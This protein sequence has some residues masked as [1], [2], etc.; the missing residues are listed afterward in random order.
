MVLSK[1]NSDI[2]YPEIKSVDPVDLK[3][4]ANLYQIDVKDVEIIIAVG[5]SKNTFEDKNILYFPIYLVKHNNKVVQIGIYEILS[6]NYINYLD[7]SNNLNVEKLDNKFIYSFIRFEYSFFG[8]TYGLV[9][10][11]IFCS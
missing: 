8:N 9:L 11:E 5:N 2:S 4:E 1:I 7:N 3:Q 10:Y 6:S